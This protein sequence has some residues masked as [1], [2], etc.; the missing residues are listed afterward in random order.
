MKGDNFYEE[1]VRRAASDINTIVERAIPMV[2]GGKAP[3]W[4]RELKGKQLAD[5][6]R[7]AD[8]PT[9]QKMWG[10]LSEQEREMLKGVYGAGGGS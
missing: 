5:F 8:L 4:T 2:R 10:S 1:V 3:P 9:K 6:Y 7:D